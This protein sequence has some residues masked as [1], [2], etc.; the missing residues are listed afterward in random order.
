MNP[1]SRRHWCTIAL[2]VVTVATLAMLASSPGSSAEGPGRRTAVTRVGT[3]GACGRD[4]GV[5]P[6]YRHVIWIWF[7]NHSYDAV[8]GSKDAP[9]TNRLAAACGLATNYHNVSHPSL[10]N[11][12][13]ATSGDTQG[14]SDDCQ[15]SECSKNVQSLFGQLR[16]RGGTWNAYNESM[17]SACDLEGG[18]GSNPAGDYAPKHNPAA[19]YLP[20]RHACRQRDVSL[21]TPSSGAF[22]R[23]LKSDGLAGFTFITPNLCNDTHDCPVATGDAW[24]ANWLPAIVSSHAYRAGSVA[25]F[26]TWDEGEGG[27]SDDCA[28]NTTDGGCHV[29]MVVVS[30][31]TQ[32][33]TRSAL[34]F[35]HY[36]LLKTTEQLLGIKTFLGHANDRSSRSMRS[37]FHL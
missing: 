4:A 34:L 3:A 35:N 13:A 6:P 12:I 22:A 19:Y 29:G 17:P 30:P 9:F 5:H 36:S 28:L 37:A 18:S 26:I 8:I 11:Y 32:R 23:A 1:L 16:A 20:L 14:I 33:G 15:P 25:I 24:L 21:G 7:E 10:P 27:G 31:S 2:V